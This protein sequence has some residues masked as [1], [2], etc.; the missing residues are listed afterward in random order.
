MNHF[1]SYFWT[2]PNVTNSVVEMLFR[3]REIGHVRVLE[4]TQNRQKPGE[5]ETKPAPHASQSKTSRM[6]S[7]EQE[8]R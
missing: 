7:R 1:G 6:H 8:M 4:A 5:F 3:V 2:N